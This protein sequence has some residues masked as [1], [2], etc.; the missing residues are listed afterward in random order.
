MPAA[1]RAEVA[2][3]PLK[4]TAVPAGN[5]DF[6][7]DV[8]CRE[9]DG[10]E[11]AQREGMIQQGIVI[12]GLVVAETVRTGF[13]GRQGCSNLPVSFNVILLRGLQRQPLWQVT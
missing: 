13:N 9:P 11:P 8:F 10:I 5:D 7:T 1:D 2:G 12:F 3:Q 6:V 4:I